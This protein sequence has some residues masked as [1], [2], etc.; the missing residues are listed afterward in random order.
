MSE[1]GDRWQRGRGTAH[2]PRS[3]TASTTGSPH[4]WALAAG[5]T[6][7]AGRGERGGLDVRGAYIRKARYKLSR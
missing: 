2:T 1:D 6:V 3:V 7:T 4:L 5:Q